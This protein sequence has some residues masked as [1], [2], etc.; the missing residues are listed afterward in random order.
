MTKLTLIIIMLIAH[1]LFYCGQIITYSV[2]CNGKTISNN[3]SL[4]CNSRSFKIVYTYPYKVGTC[5]CN[6]DNNYNDI[7]II[8]EI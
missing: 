1:I 8:E 7:Y 2:D 3:C 6:D 5:V 4:C